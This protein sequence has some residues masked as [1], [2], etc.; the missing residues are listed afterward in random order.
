MFING[1][2]KLCNLLYLFGFEIGINSIECIRDLGEL[3]NLR[4]LQVMYNYDSSA[5]GVENN[6]ETILAASLNKLGNSNLRTLDFLVHFSPW[7]PVS[8]I[9]E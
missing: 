9:L 3:T 7:P 6:P 1:L 8:T 4:N 2:S 5:D